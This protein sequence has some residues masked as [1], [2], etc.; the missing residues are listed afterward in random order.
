L[1]KCAPDPLTIQAGKGDSVRARA[2]LRS[3]ISLEDLGNILALRFTIPNLALASTTSDGNVTI[4]YLAGGVQKVQ[5]FHTL[6]QFIDTTNSFATIAS[7]I[8]SKL[9]AEKLNNT[10]MGRLKRQFSMDAS[11]TLYQLKH[12]YTSFDHTLRTSVETDETEINS[13]V[14][15]NNPSVYQ[16]PITSPLLSR[17]Q[18]EYNPDIFSIQ[19]RKKGIKRR[20]STC[21]RKCCGSILNMLNL[22]SLIISRFVPVLIVL[23]FFSNDRNT[24]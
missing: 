13:S 3:L 23:C 17:R 14:S 19:T 11:P 7:N 5:P 15:S 24:N 2:I 12:K 6:N 18:P 4:H 20:S 16:T 9:H 8:A 1:A 22:T 21:K 10:K